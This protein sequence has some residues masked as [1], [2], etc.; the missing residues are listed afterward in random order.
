[1]SGLENVFSVSRNSAR[2]KIGEN[3]SRAKGYD[4]NRLAGMGLSGVN[5]CRE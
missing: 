3:W 1:M 4:S 2:G 5:C